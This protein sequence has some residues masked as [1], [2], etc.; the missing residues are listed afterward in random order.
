MEES[1]ASVLMAEMKDSTSVHAVEEER[2]ERLS[3]NDITSSNHSEM[4]GN[5]SLQNKNQEA[6]NLL[7]CENVATF[8]SKL[9]THFTTYF[10]E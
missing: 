9:E 2:K 10:E 4:L 6:I 3:D 1:S 8:E 5:E 7:G